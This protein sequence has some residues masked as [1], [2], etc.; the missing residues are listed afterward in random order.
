M[1]GVESNTKV[2]V[3]L[4]HVGDAPPLQR[5]EVAIHREEKLLKVVAF[6][7]K[8]LNSKGGLVCRPVNPIT[9]SCISCSFPER[10]SYDVVVYCAVC[11]PEIKF[12][13]EFERTDWCPVGL[14]WNRGG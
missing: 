14:F 2:H 8:E 6:I 10:T 7:K 9:L 12:L 1:S 5:K 11:L 13:T 4:K 3:L